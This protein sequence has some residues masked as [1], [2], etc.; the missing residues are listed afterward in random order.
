[1]DAKTLKNLINARD[2]LNK[3]I[4]AES[5]P[6]EAGAG[7][8]EVVKKTPAKKA[9]KVA[10]GEEEPKKNTDGKRDVTFGPKEKS[11]LA[12]L[13]LVGIPADLPATKRTKEQVKELNKTKDNI[14]K[15]INDLTDA[16]F[17]A[18]SLEEHKFDWI[19]LNSETDDEAEEAPEE[20]TKAE[21][22]SA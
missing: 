16:D 17:D 6:A 3:I 7:K 19:K 18:K 10:A 14:K 4:D 13:E 1:M 21:E 9:A 11:T 2:A 8:A 5:A 20:E 22:I 15:Y 12:I